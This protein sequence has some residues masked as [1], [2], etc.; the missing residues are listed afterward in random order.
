MICNGKPLILAFNSD[1]ISVKL[2]RNCAKRMFRSNHKM[3]EPANTFLMGRQHWLQVFVI[4]RRVDSSPVTCT[5][6]STTANR[7]W[8][9]R[10][11]LF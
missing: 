7:I 9:K 1:I 11:R 3:S 10:F 5:K 2:W 4:A 6:N 8:R